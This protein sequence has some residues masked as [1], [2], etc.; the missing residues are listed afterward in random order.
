MNT[1]RAAK[2]RAPSR[3]RPRNSAIRTFDLTPMSSISLSMTIA[4]TLV[5]LLLAGYGLLSLFIRRGYRAPRIVE[6]GTPADCGLPFREQSIPTA[7][8]RRLFA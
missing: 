2:S 3:T 4:L 5:F 1:R 8:G 7:N 6:S